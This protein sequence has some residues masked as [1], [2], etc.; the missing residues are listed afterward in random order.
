MKPITFNDVSKSMSMEMS[1]A[2]ISLALPPIDEYVLQYRAFCIGELLLKRLIESGTL[3]KITNN[4]WGEIR[5][6]YTASKDKVICLV[7]FNGSPQTFPLEIP[8][9]A[10]VGHKDAVIQKLRK[11]ERE[12]PSKLQSWCNA[13]KNGM[14]QYCSS[15][16]ML[17]K[18]NKYQK[19]AS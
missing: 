14:V 10:L 16:E 3:K 7:Q 1:A 12:M 19:A 9:K 11:T 5:R 4:N 6:C 2:R 13:T 17:R 8:M 18:M 15:Q